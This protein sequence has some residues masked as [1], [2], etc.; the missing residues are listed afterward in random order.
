MTK[1][2]RIHITL[3][4][5]TVEE[6]DREMGPEGRFAGMDRSAVFRMFAKDAGMQVPD[7]KVGGGRPKRVVIDSGV[8]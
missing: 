8:V 1:M 7:V 3:P 4:V 6:I 2:I 5:V